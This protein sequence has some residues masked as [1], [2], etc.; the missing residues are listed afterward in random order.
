MWEALINL[1]NTSKFELSSD[2][3]EDGVYLLT[4]FTANQSVLDI[5]VLHRGY[6][7]PNNL[8]FTDIKVLGVPSSVSQVTV[9][10]NGVTIASPHT[11]GYTASK[12]LLTI[13]SLQLQL[14]QDYTLQWS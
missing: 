9:Q 12:Q 14:G 11:I 2:A 8:M 13:T 1:F 6:T 7:D 4:S 3:Y 10:Q 5:K